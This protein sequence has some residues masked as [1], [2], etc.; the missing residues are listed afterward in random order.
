MVE[1]ALAAKGLTPAGEGAPPD[2]MLSFYTG[3][4]LASD[5][6]WGYM[7]S[8]PWMMANPRY[9]NNDDFAKGVILL[10]FVDPKTKQLVWRG[11]ASKEFGE[12]VMN[13]PDQMA[14]IIQGLLPKILSG[15]PP[16]GAAH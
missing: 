12:R 6:D 13:K 1:K 7:Y 9:L 11:G 5:V 2:F 8:S 3:V 14:L 15:Y 10:D 16:S 4:G